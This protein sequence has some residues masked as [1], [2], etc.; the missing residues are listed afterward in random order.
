MEISTDGSMI[1]AAAG[2]EVFFWDAKTYQTQPSYLPYHTIPY[3]SYS[4][5]QSFHL[6][7]HIYW[8]YVNR[9]DLVHTHKLTR[10]VACVA[11]H[12]RAKAF[13]VVCS[14]SPLCFSYFIHSV[15]P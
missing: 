11:Y 14:P 8:W 9:M 5:L 10:D 6:L 7:C 2:K 12:S 3:L 1:S 15:I 13:I 4:H